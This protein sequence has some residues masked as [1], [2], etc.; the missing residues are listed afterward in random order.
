[1]ILLELFSG[2]GILSD[3]F[4]CHGWETITIDYNPDYQADYH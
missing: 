3:T 4:K 1:M 2:S